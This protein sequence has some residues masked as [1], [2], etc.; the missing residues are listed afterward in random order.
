M[1]VVATK[2][3]LHPRAL[4]DKPSDIKWA[5]YKHSR[6]FGLTTVLYLAPNRHHAPGLVT[7]IAFLHSMQKLDGYHLLPCRSSKSRPPALVYIYMKTSTTFAYEFWVHFALLEVF[8]YA[9]MNITTL[10]L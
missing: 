3:C 4:P 2:L 6:K 9:T 1:A 5:R 10:I 7:S 8:C